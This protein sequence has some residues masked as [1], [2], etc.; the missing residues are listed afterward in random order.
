[1]GDIASRPSRKPVVI[2]ELHCNDFL[3]TNRVKRLAYSLVLLFLLALPAHT[4]DLVD[5]FVARSYT[6]AAR[7]TMPYRLF[8]PE[9]YSEDQSYPLVLWLH[10]SGGAGFDNLKQIQGDQIEGTHLWINFEN[11][12][13]FPAF[14]LVPQSG[15]PWTPN[16][17]SVLSQE[18]SLVLGIL[19]TV[20]KEFR[21]D[22]TRLYIAG[23]SDGAFGV[24]NLITQ[25]P[26]MFA[27]AIIVCGGGS[28]A[29]AGR[30][31]HMAIWMFHGARDSAVPV[32]ESRRMVNALT[33][34]GGNP[35]YTEYPTLGHE[36]WRRAF[37]ERELAEWLFSQRRVD[38]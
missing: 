3:Y 10:G 13:R 32:D 1:M 29:V 12:E 36:V 38:H 20:Q 17:R 2:G 4:Q 31:A 8:V 19:E 6:N 34:S 23:Q 25:R 27:G 9:S 30:V 14:V 16:G 28:P 5:G 37:A 24:W 18:L 21:I 35:R 7:R 11:Q 26:Q 22:S 15:G 33:R